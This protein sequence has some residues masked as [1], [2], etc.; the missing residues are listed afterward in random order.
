MKSIYD[1]LSK[2]CSKL[3]THMYST[4]FS[5]GIKLLDKSLHDPIYA[6]Y[7]FVRLADEIVDSFHDFPK[8]KLLAEFRADTYRSINEGISLNP[9]LNSFQLAVNKYDIS[10][11]LI[12]T[13]LKSMEMDLD[14]KQHD[15]KSY[16]TYILGSAEVVG[17][18]CLK[19]FCHEHTGLYEKLNFSAKKLGAAFQ[20]INFL[21]DLKDDYVLLG[22]NYF[23]E[24]DF[25]NFSLENKIK[26]ETEIKQDFDEGLAGILQLPKTSR[27]G[28]YLAFIYYKALFSKIQKTPVNRILKERIRVP[29]NHKYFLLAKTF[30]SHKF[31]L[32]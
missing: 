6:I 18:M 16:E 32:K 14:Q 5:A 8:E 4:S 24:V 11:D 31:A 28:V 2:N 23:P 19:V 20:K 13:F 9:I 3:T 27:H 22:R 10:H 25:E 26:L 21:R 30:I 1:N 29:D 7:G 17:L 15:L 12:D